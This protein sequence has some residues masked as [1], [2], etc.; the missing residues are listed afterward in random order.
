MT[1]A[2]IIVVVLALLLA[3]AGLIALV[4]GAGLVGAI[5]LGLGAVVAASTML[6]VFT[7]ARPPSP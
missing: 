6:V 4:M 2:Q 7:A 5:M 1:R 3:L